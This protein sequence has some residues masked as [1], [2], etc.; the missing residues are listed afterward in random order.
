MDRSLLVKKTLVLVGLFALLLNSS[1]VLLTE[2]QGAAMWS[3]KD[4]SGVRG[5]VTIGPVK[6]VQRVG[7]ENTKPFQ[8]KLVVKTEDGTQEI[9]K[10]SSGPNGEFQIELP[11]GSYTI[12]RDQGSEKYP[13]CDPTKVVVRPN[14]FSKVRITCDTGIR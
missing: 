10:F 4:K 1:I 13:R 2:A 12:E 5:I 8:T 7:E 14:K 11:P 9:M 6:P 3:K